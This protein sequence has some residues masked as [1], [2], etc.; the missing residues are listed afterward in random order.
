MVVSIPYNIFLNL[1]KRDDTQLY[2]TNIPDNVIN[3]DALK[4]INDLERLLTFNRSL[5]EKTLSA[6]AD[7][8]KHEKEEYKKTTN[9]YNINNNIE[10]ENLP[11]IIVS[12]HENPN[13]FEN[14]Y[15]DF[16]DFTEELKIGDINV[17][18]KK[19]SITLHNN[20]LDFNESL[21]DSLP[22]F[23]STEA[24][25]IPNNCKLQT[26]IHYLNGID[27]ATIDC[28]RA[29]L[30]SQLVY[31]NTKIVRLFNFQEC[32][33]RNENL[34]AEGKG[35]KYLG[36][37]QPNYQYGAYSHNIIGGGNEIERFNNTNYVYNDKTDNLNL[38]NYNYVEHKCH[39]WIDD[40]LKRVYV[41][42]RGTASTHDWLYT[43]LAIAQGLGFQEGR[44]LQIKEILNVFL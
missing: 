41:V 21:T 1:Y 28:Q 5:D 13:A 4:L 35:L 32:W 40:H 17:N 19:D 38:S 24:R 42:F 27:N 37:Y 8:K 15:T 18:V 16:G 14:M 31:E 39:V 10:T 6:M 12:E 36:P 2:I 20:Y 3:T 43:D 22:D 30:M 23:S 34:N 11:L 26:H 7:Y 29:C 33:N 44:L 25:P 9:I